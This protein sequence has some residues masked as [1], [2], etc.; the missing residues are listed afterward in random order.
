MCGSQKLNPACDGSKGPETMAQAADADAVYEFFAMSCLAV[1]ML[2][3]EQGQA[4]VP[5]HAAT[6]LYDKAQCQGL[7]MH[8]WHDWIHDEFGRLAAQEP[9]AAGACSVAMQ[10]GAQGEAN[11]SETLEEAV[12]EGNVESMGAA[13]AAVAGCPQQ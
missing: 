11:C 4:P 1:N 3:I 9:P 13:Y 6:K 10:A 2:R 7:P 12:R 8:R 5:Q